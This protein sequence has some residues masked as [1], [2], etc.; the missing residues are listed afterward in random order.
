MKMK[1]GKLNGEVE[2]RRRRTVLGPPGA[3]GESINKR[4]S[5]ATQLVGSSRPSPFFG[6]SCSS[7]FSSSRTRCSSLLDIQTNKLGGPP[8]PGPRMN[9]LKQWNAD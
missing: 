3:G 6:P 7:S 4:R 9:H 8:W 1:L 5:P 2:E